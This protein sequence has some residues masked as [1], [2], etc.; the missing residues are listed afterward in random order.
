MAYLPLDPQHAKMLLTAPDFRCVNEMLSIVACLSV[1][2]LFMRP[3]EAAREADSAKAQFAHADGDHLTMLNAFHAYKEN[4]A[5]KDWCWDNFLNSRSLEAADNVRRQL[6]SQIQRLG[7]ELASAD[8]SSAGYY[9]NIRKA[10]AGGMFLQAAHLE[11]SGHYLTCKDNQVVSIHPSSV[12]GSKP[13]WVAYEDFV[14]TNKNYIRTVTV[15]EP[16]WLVEMAP[17]YFDL[18]NFPPGEARDDLVKVHR[19]L[20][21]RRSR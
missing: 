16:E 13:E 11:R 3:K 5:S 21:Y 7:I 6:Q 4:G 20:E 14:L 17:Q 19:R 12:I 2:P 15:V 8:P 10:I 1:Q 18:D 9:R